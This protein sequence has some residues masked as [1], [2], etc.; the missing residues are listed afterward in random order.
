MLGR[1]WSLW[2]ENS[3]LSICSQDSVLSIGS[4]A[5][6]ASFASVGSFASAGS[7]GSAMSGASLLSYQSTGSVLSHQ[8]NGAVLSSQTD[9]ALLGRRTDG[10]VPPAWWGL[11]SCPCWSRSPSI[12]PSG[13]PDHRSARVVAADLETDAEPALDGYLVVA[14]TVVRITQ[15]HF[16]ILRS[17]VKPNSSKRDSG[18]VWR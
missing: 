17:R 12:G 8:S 5:S 13:H 15:R 9:H 3:V 6:V 10:S 14:G 7:I 2:S 4:A 18:P 11:R 1:M 16:A